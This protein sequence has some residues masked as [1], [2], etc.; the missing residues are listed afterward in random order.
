MEM[1]QFLY[2]WN[3]YIMFM[4]KLIDLNKSDLYTPDLWMFQIVNYLT[5]TVKVPHSK[6]FE[7]IAFFL[8]WSI[9]F[10]KFILIDNKKL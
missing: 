5:D 2:F 4:H 6:V 7:A 8:F 3:T 9:K 10:I 1:D